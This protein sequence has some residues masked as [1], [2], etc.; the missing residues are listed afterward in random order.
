[1]DTHSHFLV[2]DDCNCCHYVANAFTL[3]KL[4]LIKISL[5]AVLENPEII[6]HAISMLICKNV[7]AAQIKQLNDIAENSSH[8]FLISLNSPPAKTAKPERRIYYLKVPFSVSDL[9]DMLSESSN[10]EDHLISQTDLHDPLFERLVGKSKQ[11]SIIK[12][13][14]KQVAESDTTVLISGESGT[15]KEVIASCIHHLS[16]RKYKIFVPINCGAIPSELMESELFGHEKGAFTGAATRRQGRFEI[17]NMGSLFLDEI[18]DMP[19]PMQVKL[20]RVI[21]ERKIERVGSTQSIDVNVRLIAA[22]NR[23]LEDMIQE[24]TFREDLFYRLNVFPIQVPNLHERREDI[25]LVIEFHLD[26]IQERLGHR[27]VFTERALEIL[28]AYP[29][30]GNIRELANF[31]ERMVILHRDCVLDEKDLD[32]VYKQKKSAFSH[33]IS[34][35]PSEKPFNIK[36]YIAKIEQQLINVALERSNGIVNV[37]AEYLSMGKAALLEKIKKYKINDA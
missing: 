33:I 28:C 11:I 31:L 12:S 10:Q 16:L 7:N 17:A 15:G 6:A 36:E 37:A 22:T 25:P 9:K 23:K 3:L 14:I 20:L 35:W 21:Q 34:H 2:N 27:V 13:H 32:D 18:G 24:N 5:S 29:W 4:P 26:K 8:V 30:P 19:L 1:M